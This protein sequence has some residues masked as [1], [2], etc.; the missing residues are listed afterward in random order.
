[1]LAIAFHDSSLKPAR[2][3]ARHLSMRTVL[4]F[5][6][7]ASGALWAQPLDLTQRYLLLATTRTPTM[8]KELNQAAAAGYRVLSGAH[9][10]GDDGDGQLMVLLE[11]VARPPEVYTYQLLATERTKTMQRELDRFAAQGFRLLPGSMIG[12]KGELVLLLEKA[13]RRIHQV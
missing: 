3:V 6:L 13:P 5:A 11:K 7:A 10:T 12:G 4:A 1:M 9:Q 8:Q 2:S